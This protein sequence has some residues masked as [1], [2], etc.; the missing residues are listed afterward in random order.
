MYI[1][2]TD[3]K[4]RQVT[5]SYMVPAPVWKSSY[6]LILPET[7]KPV[8]EGWAIVDNTTGEDWTKVRLSLV[9]G[10]PISFISQLYAPRY[11]GR[12]SA[13]LPEDAAAR[14]VLHSGGYYGGTP[15]RCGPGFRRR[16]DRREYECA[17]APAPNGRQGNAG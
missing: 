16:N 12:P 14:P 15:E 4:E 1:D 6:R 3:A 10:R 7:G 13:E 11:V 8:L 9:S 2:S 5:A 17:S